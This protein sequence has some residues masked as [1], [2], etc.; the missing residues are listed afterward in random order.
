MLLTVKARDA[1]HGLWRVCLLQSQS[2]SET[3]Y[4]PGGLLDE[5]SAKREMIVRSGLTKLR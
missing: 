2:E 5:L 3:S 1:L 4:L